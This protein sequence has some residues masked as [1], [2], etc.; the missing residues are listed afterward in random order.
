MN[1]QNPYMDQPPGSREAA[2][3]D[4]LAGWLPLIGGPGQ[5]QWRFASVEEM[6]LQLPQDPGFPALLH[7]Y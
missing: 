2:N 3:R 4:Y 1:F 5:L 7:S 6:A